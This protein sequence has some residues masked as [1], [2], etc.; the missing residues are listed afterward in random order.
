[1]RTRGLRIASGSRLPVLIGIKKAHNYNFGVVFK[2]PSYVKSDDCQHSWCMAIRYRNNKASET[3]MKNFRL[4]RDTTGSRQG[5]KSSSQRNIA[6][7]PALPS[8]A[9][10]P[11]EAPNP[12]TI[13]GC[14]LI[15]KFVHAYA[16]SRCV[17]S[18][19]RMHAR[20]RPHEKEQGADPVL[21]HQADP[22]GDRLASTSEGSA[23]VRV[24]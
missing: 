12:P 18:S 6:E 15:P 14:A 13:A 8:L 21:S 20:K 4:T 5:S 22:P 17:R 19:D 1:M 23:L 11:R 9:T 3:R 7:A 24:E 2:L 10:S 16:R